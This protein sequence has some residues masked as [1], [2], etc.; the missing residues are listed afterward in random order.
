[1]ELEPAAGGFYAGQPPFDVSHGELVSTVH[2]YGRFARML[3]DGGRFEG[4]Q[5]V[6]EEHLR[7]MTSDQVPAI[8]KTP[9]SFF[10]G[11]GRYRLG[12]RRRCRHR[13]RAGR[14]LRVVRR[15]R[16]QLLCRP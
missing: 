3:A 16:H 14:P 13:G 11:L 1:V 15:T 6:S 12:L 8:A 4:R 5:I 9:D 7:L 10:P 2:D